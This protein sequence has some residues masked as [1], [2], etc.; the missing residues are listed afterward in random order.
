MLELSQ[1]DHRCFDVPD[2][3]LLVQMLDA[4][5]RLGNP[6]NKSN[7]YYVVEGSGLTDVNGEK[8]RLEAGRLFVVPNWSWHWHRNSSANV[9]AV[10]FSTT[11]RPLQEAIGVYREETR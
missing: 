4:A 5:K 1:P 6:T 10:L 2:F 9:P 11:D 8:A 7:H 3:F